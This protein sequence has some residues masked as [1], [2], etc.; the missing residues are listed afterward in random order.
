[1]FVDLVGEFSAESP[2]D[3]SEI[4]ALLQQ[5]DFFN[6]KDS[7]VDTNIVD[8]PTYTLVVKQG[9]LIKKIVENGD[10]PYEVKRIGAYLDKQISKIEA[11]NWSKIN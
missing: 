1:M 4:Q 5:V 7:Y 2:K 10:A 6:L 8:V 9:K 11:T 3:F